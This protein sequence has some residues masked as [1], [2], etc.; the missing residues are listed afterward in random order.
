MCIEC[1][2]VSHV[3]ISLTCLSTLLRIH[4]SCYYF[5]L[6]THL[7]VICGLILVYIQNTSQTPAKSDGW[8]TEFVP[9]LISS[10]VLKLDIFTCVLRLSNFATGIHLAAM[11][12]A[13]IQFQLILNNLFS[14][15]ILLV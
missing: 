12:H 5:N 13:T 15:F 2:C 10:V 3:A 6:E 8:V 11:C 9:T 7:R 4:F 14:Y 1:K